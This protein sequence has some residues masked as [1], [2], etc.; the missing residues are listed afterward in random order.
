M[1]EKKFTEKDWD[2]I[3]MAFHTSIMVDTSLVS[4]AQNLDT[5]A[6]PLTGEEETPAKY[7]DLSYAELSRTLSL[8]GCPE[9]LNHLIGILRDTMAFDNPFGEMVQQTEVHASKDN[10]L[11][12]NFAKVE[13]PESY[14]IGLTQLSSDT[15][16]FC[17]RENLSTL[18]QFAVFAQGMS[19]TVIVSG[20]FR[21]LLNAVANI[22]ESAL[23]EL[24]PFRT[25]GKGLH[26]PEALALPVN[27]LAPAMRYALLRNFGA[28]LTREETREAD[29]LSEEEVAAAAAALRARADQFFAWFADEL[30]ELKV[31]VDEGG[32]IERYLMV[33]NDPVAETLASV[34]LQPYLK[35]APPVQEVKKAKKTGGFLGSLARLFGKK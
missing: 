20:D 15:L 10:Q 12:K 32:S 27:A 26:L 28:Q 24:M 31:Q 33:L 1:A 30:A 6:W 5:D 22:D 7:I 25:G 16:E 34:L 29:A 14:P 17:Q 4:L 9:N 8:A 13:I 21:K 11:L 19:K 23:A 35:P 2:D 3:R 18:A